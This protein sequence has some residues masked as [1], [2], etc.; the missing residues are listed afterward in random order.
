MKYSF[1]VPN[2]LIWT[3]HILTGI[4]FLWLGYQMTNLGSL[5]LHGLVLIVLGSL[6]ATYHAHLWFY[7][8]EKKN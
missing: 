6:M 7:H 8:K 4:Y 1:G 3:V 2:F 5:K